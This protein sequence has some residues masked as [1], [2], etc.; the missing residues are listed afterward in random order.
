V[1]KWGKIMLNANVSGTCDE[2]F[3]EI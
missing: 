1:K 2:K 3:T